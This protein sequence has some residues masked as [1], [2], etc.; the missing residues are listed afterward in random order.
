VLLLGCLAARAHLL[1]RLGRHAEAAETTD[2]QR[3]VA[4]RL[5]SPALAATA[6]HDAG[7]VA[8][9]AGDHARAAALLAEALEGRAPVSRASAGLYRAEAL[10]LAGDAAAATAQLRAAMLEAVGRAD[11]PWAL[12]P[13]IAWVQGLIAR[14]RGEPALARRRFEEAATGWRSML[15]TVAGATADGYTAALLDL[16]RPPVAGLVEPQRELARVR[17]ALTSSG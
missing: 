16:G 1:A 11:Q 10:A 4:G 5:D 17:T 15:S 6:A 14:S 2:R 7:L 3:A 13:R 9:A 8:L 12:V